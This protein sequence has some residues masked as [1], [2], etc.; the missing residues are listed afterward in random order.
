MHIIKNMLKRQ[1]IVSFFQQPA[2]RQLCLLHA[3]VLPGSLS[4]VPHPA[5]Q[6]RQ[7]P[8]SLRRRPPPG[9]GDQLQPEGG[10]A[11]EGPEGCHDVQVGGELV[12]ESSLLR[13]GVRLQG[14]GQ[15]LGSCGQI[16]T[17][18]SW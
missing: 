10:D 9:P 17:S 13:S 3:G 16:E 6:D 5:D 4:A 7:A 14:S 18:L 8:R 11:V 15:R 12:R 1:L 2:S